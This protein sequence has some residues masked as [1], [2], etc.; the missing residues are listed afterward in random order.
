MAK[1]RVIGRANA[2]PWHLPSE[3]ARFR[4]ITMGH[5]IV[6]GRKTWASIGRLLPGRTTVIVT[7]TRCL[8]VD[9]ALVA[10]SLVA[11]LAACGDDTEPFV[12]GGAQLFAEALPL[13]RRIYLTTV[14]AQIE[15][16][17]V[18]PE[19]D[20]SA[21]REIE[22]ERVEAGAGQALAYDFVILERRAPHAEGV[23]S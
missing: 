1:N 19:F 15:G 18:M 10:H 20:R 8:A 21:Y 6:M 3:L 14:D 13:A 16:D 12:I 23:R 9:G 7:R 2:M 4:R 5:H 22:R 11:A 17:V